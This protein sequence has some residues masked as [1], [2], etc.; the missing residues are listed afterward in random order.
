MITN[1]LTSWIDVPAAY[2]GI[3][4]WR[5]DD[6]EWWAYK[7]LAAFARRIAGGIIAAGV[8]H[9]DRVLVIERTGPEFVAALYGVMLAGAIPCPVAP[10]PLFQSEMHYA[11]HLQA[12]SEVA[13]PSLVI[14]YATLAE[15]LTYGGYETQVRTAAQLAAG[16]E[17]AARPPAGAALLQFTSGSSGRV[18]GVRVPVSALASNV[19]A[20]R[21]WLEMG[22]GDATASWLP[23]HHDMGLIGCLLTPVV[24]QRDL[25]LQEPADFVR[26]PARYLACFS[27][28]GAAMTAMPP[29]G[30]DYIAR[31]VSPELLAGSDF[32]GWRALIIG[33][34]RI[35]I[36]VLERFMALMGPFGFDRRA[37]LPAYGLAEATLA[38]T[39]LALR[40]NLATVPVAPH[41]VSLGE[42]VTST[43][44]DARD[45]VGCGRALDGVTVSVV[46]DAG[47]P[48]PDRHVGQIVVGGAS[49]AEGY[50][51]ENATSLTEWRDGLL[52]TGDAGFL[53]D[54]QLYVIGRLGDA[55]KVRGR[56]VFAE[57][58]ESALVEA[59]V[60][61][62]RVAVLL[63]ST[64]AGPTAVVLLERPQAEWIEAA[65]TVSQRITE[66]VAMEILDVPRRSIYRTT[67]GKP[68][69]RDMWSA[70]VA[71]NIEG[72]EVVGEPV[73]SVGN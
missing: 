21:A 63:G 19:S 49:V 70:Y 52:W 73:P 51:T 43:G 10:P 46:D 64:A 45:V 50:V 40:E 58:I 55:M 8:R 65:R 7:D 35:D 31:R 3:R 72:T 2:R 6:W 48:L 33:A 61:R 27:A 11:R 23:V 16:D 12:I 22:E 56:T 59:G 41:L 66:G 30:L 24:Q 68:K 18:K 47:E 71:H 38:V 13:A 14:T 42:P 67:S 4:F 57:D 39:G 69:R 62:L 34:E 54:G 28:P 1:P 60:P 37:L 44:A 29:F 5:N 53:D 26:D 36:E 17:A 9:D 15:Q 25:W 32:S 20:I